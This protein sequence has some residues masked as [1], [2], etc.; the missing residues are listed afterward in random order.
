MQAFIKTHR[1][2]H[3]TVSSYSGCTV[4]FIYYVSQ[5]SGAPFKFVRPAKVVESSN[6]ASA[7]G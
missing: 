4:Y 3:G 6:G 7:L 1:W 5:E 2:S